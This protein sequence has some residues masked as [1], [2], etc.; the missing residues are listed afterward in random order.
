MWLLSLVP[1]TA[2][3][4]PA[5]SIVLPDGQHQVFVPMQRGEELYNAYCA[6]CHGG[7][8]GGR[9]MDFPPVHNANGHTWHHPD[10]QLR[11]IIHN[12]GGEMGDMMRRMMG[13][14]DSP[15]MPAFADTLTDEEIDAILGY[16]KTWWTPQQRAMQATATEQRC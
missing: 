10:C 16:I 15:R 6:S 3:L 14:S 2:I 8:T 7:R 12:G 13:S 9:M 5:W 11:E 1:L 4:L